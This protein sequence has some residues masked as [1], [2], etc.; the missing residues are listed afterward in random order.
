MVRNFIK[1]LLQENVE[2]LSF[3]RTIAWI[4]KTADNWDQGGHLPD[5]NTFREFEKNYR[6]YANKLPDD[7]WVSLTEISNEIRK[8]EGNDRVEN[9]WVQRAIRFVDYVDENNSIPSES[10]LGDVILMSDTV[11]NSD[12]PQWDKDDMLSVLNWAEDEIIAQQ[13]LEHR[14]KLIGKQYKHLRSVPNI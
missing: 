14:E 10:D 3:H 11:S 5:S 12:L 8:R 7:V 2:E 4:L 9:I 13:E 6:K 1:I